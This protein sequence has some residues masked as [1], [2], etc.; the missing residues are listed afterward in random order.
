MPVLRIVAFN[1]VLQVLLLER[2]GLEGEVLVGP[3]VVD[4]Q[5]ATALA[6]HY[7]ISSSSQRLASQIQFICQSLPEEMPV[8]H[9]YYYFYYAIYYAICQMS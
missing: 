8:S 5:S 1:E 3:Q 2:I 4:P 9:I 6:N 7:P